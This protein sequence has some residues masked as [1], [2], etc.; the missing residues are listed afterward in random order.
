MSIRAVQFVK[1][2]RGGAQSQLMRASDGALYVVKFQNNPQGKRV[3]ANELIATRLAQVIGLP[4]A[5]CTIIEVR[6]MLIERTPE[7]RIESETHS[8]PCAP[9]L[10]TA[11]RFVAQ[12]GTSAQVWD[13]LPGALLNSTRNLNAFAGMLAFDW[14]TFNRDSR[15]A[16]FSRIGCRGKCTATFIDQGYCFNGT[17]WTF[18][19]MNVPC[20]YPVRD[21]YAVVNG[22]RS[23]EPWLSRIERLRESVLWDVVADIPE[24]WEVPRD[25]I[26]DLVNALQERQKLVR[27]FI[28]D[29]RSGAR[30]PFQRWPSYRTTIETMHGVPSQ[31][32]V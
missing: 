24:E 15:Q 23:F 30:S 5:P 27:G 11:S 2:M 20:V 17:R 31:C 26:K 12:T 10:Q 29:L 22:W 1:R 9:G 8:V 18:P 16:V 28:D 6:S 4:V 3:L 7:L 32:C 19:E 14:W 13:W 21:V 25:A